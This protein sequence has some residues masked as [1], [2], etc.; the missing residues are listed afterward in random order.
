MKVFISWSGD[1]SKE[2]ALALSV[3]LKV[4]LQFVETW[5]SDDDIGAGERWALVLGDE[6]EKAQFGIV[7]MTR[8]NLD[9]KWIHFESGALAKAIGQRVVPYLVDLDLK[10]FSAG[11]LSL[12]QAKKSDKKGTLDLVRSI[13]ES[14]QS[15]LDSETLEKS[16]DL[17]WPMLQ[18]DLASISSTDS[19]LPKPTP[20]DDVLEN[21]VEAMRDMNARIARLDSSAPEEGAPSRVVTVKVLDP[22]QGRTRT[23]RFYDV[24]D[25]FVKVGDLHSLALADYGQTWWLDSASQGGPI[26]LSAKHEPGSVVFPKG[27]DRLVLVREDSVL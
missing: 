27:E 2:A 3:W 13:N 24:V 17:A 21:L 10:E 6:L 12:F 4:V 22:Q 20:N 26:P 18:S 1:A 14:H 9:S 5:V 25:L 16:F 23:I 7:C 19:S 11:P 15:P 8:D